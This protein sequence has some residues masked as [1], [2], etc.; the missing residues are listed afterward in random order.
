MMAC[1]VLCAAGGRS[2]FY[3]AISDGA[4]AAATTEEERPRHVDQ[5]VV[6][7][8]RRRSLVRPVY[9]LGEQVGTRLSVRHYCHPWSALSITT[10]R[11]RA[12]LPGRF[13]PR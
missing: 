2:A 11:L 9:C 12:A 7:R 4:A 6:G 3:E 10:D 8:L 13:P 1:A 5:V